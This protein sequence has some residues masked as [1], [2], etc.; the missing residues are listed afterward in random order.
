MKVLADPDPKP[1]DQ[2]IRGSMLRLQEISNKDT[3]PTPD[4]SMQQLYASY[5]NPE[6]NGARRQNRDQLENIYKD[7]YSQLYKRQQQQAAQNLASSA[8]RAK[9]QAA[10][11]GY[12][13]EMAAGMQDRMMSGAYSANQQ[14]N[15][16]LNDQQREMSTELANYEMRAREEQSNENM[17][18]IDEIAEKHPELAKRL[19]TAL[20][21]GQPI[22]PEDLDEF[23][24]EDGTFKETNVW[25]K[26]EKAANEER[27]YYIN[28]AKEGNEAARNYIYENFTTNPSEFAKASGNPNK[29]VEFFETTGALNDDGTYNGKVL[30]QIINSNE[31]IQG[32]SHYDLPHVY[33]NANPGDVIIWGGRPYILEEKAFNQGYYGLRITDPVTGQE[34][35]LKGNP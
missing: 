32:N 5:T 12:N 19:K 21:L 16:N 11:A 6:L 35:V 25:E 24:N 20:I 17:R 30:R 9:Q 3:A 15:A 4:T 28:A 27:E 10:L 7:T 8:Y 2:S 1:S 33:N 34:H 22:N 31:L 14:G 18:R 13:P 26:A 23:I 29:L